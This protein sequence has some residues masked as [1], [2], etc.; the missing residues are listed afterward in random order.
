MTILPHIL[1][2]ESSLGGDKVDPDFEEEFV[3]AKQNGFETLIFNFEDLINFEQSEKATKRI[4]PAE[5]LCS[6]IYRGWMMTPQQY[7]ILYNNLLVKNYKLINT[8]D[9]Y[10]NCHYLP[11]SLKF[12][13]NKTPKTIF[14]KLSKESSFDELIED[15]KIFQN[16]P[17][18]IKDYVK[19]EKHHWE[20][21]CFVPNASNTQQLKQIINNFIKLRGQYL[22]VGI[23]IRE[24]IELNELTIHSKSGMPLTEEYRLFFYNKK[25]VGIYDYWEEGEYILSKPNTKEFEEIAKQLESNFFS[26]DIAR[27]KDG[28]FVIIELGDG[29]VSSLPEKVNKN[30]FYKILRDSICN[31]LY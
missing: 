24:F 16:K 6:V 26:M 15:A 28:E 13:E 7:S 11:N 22:N 31:G 21:A 25:L 8:V 27:R 3:L 14:E 23:V 30:E 20:T 18:I 10:Q 4:K 2:C 19:S 1:F 29:Q 5:T 12:I 17:V 9:E